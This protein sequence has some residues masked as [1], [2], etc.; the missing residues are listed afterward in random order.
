MGQILAALNAIHLSNLVPLVYHPKR[1]LRSRRRSNSAKQISI[2][3]YLTC[4]D[5]IRLV[6]T[7]QCQLTLCKNLHPRVGFRGMYRTSHHFFTQDRET[8]MMLELSSWRCSLAWTS[9]IDFW[10]PSLL[11]ILV[12]GCIISMSCESTS[13]S[14][15]F[16]YAC[17]TSSNH[18][19]SDEEVNCHEFA[20][21]FQRRAIAYSGCSKQDTIFTGRFEFIILSGVAGIHVCC[22]S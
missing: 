15:N 22:R 6:Y 19:S 13:S 17:Q 21:R 7:H 14:V 10:T 5:P 8:F 1:I 2:R 18:D 11:F 12:S 4:T 20:I 3:V 16:A 9:S